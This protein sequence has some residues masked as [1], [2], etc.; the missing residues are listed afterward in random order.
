MMSVL[1]KLNGFREDSEAGFTLMEIIVV[2]LIMGVLAAI[3]IPIFMNQRANAVDDALMTDLK[4]IVQVADSVRS[5]NPNAGY[6]VMR[7]GRICAGATA[8]P[9][10]CP[11]TAPKPTLTTVGASFG[12]SGGGGS[13]GANGT[14]FASAW[15]PEA[16]QYNSYATRLF[17]SSFEETYKKVG[18]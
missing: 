5:N 3:A 17:Y 15:H 14:F 2:I 8:Y 11:A 18:T 4:N 1:K 16:N 6:I 9:S 13:S 7:S 12:I 10:T